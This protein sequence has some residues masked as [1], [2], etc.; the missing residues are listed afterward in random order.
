MSQLSVLHDCAPPSRRVASVSLAAP[1]GDAVV[2]RIPRPS[3]AARVKA[4]RAKVVR[5]EASLP[6]HTGDVVTALARDLGHSRNEVLYNLIQFA[7]TNRNWR[8]LGLMGSGR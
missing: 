3:S 2:A 5:L 8:Q 6:V 4:H 1:A 7:L